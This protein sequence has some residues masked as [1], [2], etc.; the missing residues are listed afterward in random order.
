[1][2]EPLICELDEKSFD[3]ETF[4]SSKPVLVF[5]GAEE[6]CAV[7]RNLYPIV[8]T[9]AEAY[10]GKLKVKKVDVDRYPG[11]A[12]RFRLRGIPVLFLFK[13][14]MVQDRLSGYHDKAAIID[15]LVK[16]SD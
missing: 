8:E 1:M 5:F 12:S 2:I 15:W 6:R 13:E 11:L 10:S 9:V 7:C 16:Y 4:D 3:S 14:G